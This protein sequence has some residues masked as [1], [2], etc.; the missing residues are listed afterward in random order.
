MQ[1]QKAFDPTEIEIEEYDLGS[2]DMHAAAIWTIG[3]ISPKTTTVSVTIATKSDVY[4]DK[5]EGI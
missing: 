5:L 3:I 2:D 4:Q 1:E